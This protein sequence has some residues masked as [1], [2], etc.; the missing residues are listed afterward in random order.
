MDTDWM[1]KP[2]RSGYTI[3]NSIGASGRGNGMTYRL[4]ANVRTVKG[5]MQKDYRN[6]IG[7][8]MFLSYHVDNKLTVSFQSSFSDL[9]WKESPYGKF[10]DYVVMNHYDSPYYE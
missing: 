6:T 2:L 7:L 1:S 8:N 4:N 5:V 9:K 3:N 10:S